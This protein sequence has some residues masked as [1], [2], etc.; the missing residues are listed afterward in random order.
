[1]RSPL[2]GLEQMGLPVTGAVVR[3]GWQGIGMLGRQLTAPQVKAFAQE[4]IGTAEDALLA[5]AAVLC[6]PADDQGVGAALARLAPWPCGRA[7]RIWQVYLFARLLDELPSDA[8]EGLC[9]LTDFWGAFDFPEGMPHVVQGSG[10]AIAPREYDDEAY[11][12]LLV[13]RH[14]EWLHQEI[15]ELASADDSHRRWLDA[16]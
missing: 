11:Y 15:A 14:R 2:D 8:V 4:R 9:A 1:M 3:A 16:P 10:N 13:S 7:V 12:R 6:F 5:D